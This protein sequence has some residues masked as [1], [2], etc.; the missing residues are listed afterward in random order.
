MNKRQHKKMMKKMYLFTN[1][2]DCFV[3]CSVCSNY[4]F[5]DFSVGIPSGCYVPN[6]CEN[7][8]TQE[9]INE[10]I[11]AHMD[12]LG[13]TCPYF[14]PLKDKRQYYNAC[15]SWREY[16]QRKARQDAYFRYLEK[17]CCYD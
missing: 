8:K 10:K 15:K 14:R 13:Y 12:N 6:D 7:E 16:K 9:K 11:I 1:L 5:E 17:L 3:K 2:E 4:E